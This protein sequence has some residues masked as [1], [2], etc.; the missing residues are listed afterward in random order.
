MKRR[1]GFV[2][3]SSSSSFIIANENLTIQQ[4]NRIVNHGEEA[5]SIPEIEWHDD[6]W[7]IELDS[8]SVRGSTYMNNFDMGYFLEFIGVKNTDITW[9]D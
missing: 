6:V 7:F 2:S 9:E 3:N 5:K 4:M 1:Q 8:V